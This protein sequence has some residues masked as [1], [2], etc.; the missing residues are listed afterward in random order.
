MI[1]G[2]TE[3]IPDAFESIAQVTEAMSDP[4]YDKD[5]AY[6]ASVEKKIA[7]SSVI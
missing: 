5:P 7:R 6:R 2:E 3:I 4:R 1:Q